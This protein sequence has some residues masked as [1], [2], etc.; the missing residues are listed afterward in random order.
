MIP[1]LVMFMGMGMKKAIGTSL[2]IIAANSL[3]GFITDLSHYSID[4]KFLTVISSVAILGVLIGS[5]LNKNVSSDILKK[6]FGW[7]VLAMA[8]FILVKEIF[9]HVTV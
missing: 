1:A 5:R 3:I 6:I 8:L 4:W 9:F 7:F 2:M